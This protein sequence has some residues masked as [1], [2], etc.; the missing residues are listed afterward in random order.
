MKKDKVKKKFWDLKQ[1][2]IFVNKRNGQMI[3]FLPKKKMNKMPKYVD[4][5]WR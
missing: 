3:V 5:K 1:L 2:P 4:V